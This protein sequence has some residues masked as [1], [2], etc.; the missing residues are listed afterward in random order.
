MYQENEPVYL[1]TETTL[2]DAIR[3]TIKSEI[4]ALEERLVKK[5]RIL[6]RDE[7]AKKQGVCPNTI[8]E[9]VRSGRLPNRGLGRKILISEADLEEVKRNRYTHY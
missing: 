4:K 7:A 2:K 3:E 9:Y 8:S 6:T 5:S 1:I